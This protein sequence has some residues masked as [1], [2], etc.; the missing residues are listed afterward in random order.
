MGAIKAS[1]LSF[2]AN[3]NPKNLTEMDV[4][5]GFNHFISRLLYGNS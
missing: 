3:L 5:M 1:E 2:E 4:V